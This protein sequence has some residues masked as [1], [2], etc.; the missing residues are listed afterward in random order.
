MIKPRAP[1]I[2]ASRRFTVWTVGSQIASMPRDDAPPARDR[3]RRAF[4]GKKVEVSRFK[5]LGEMNPEQ[6]KETTPMD[7]ATGPAAALPPGI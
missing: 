1:S 5:G 7:P 2:L 6:L 4:K 3:G